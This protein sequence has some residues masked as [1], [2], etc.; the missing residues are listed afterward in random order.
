MSQSFP[1]SVLA[2]SPNEA[3]S[4]ENVLGGD[5]L[6]RSRFRKLLLLSISLELITFVIGNSTNNSQTTP[7]HFSIVPLMILSL[8]LIAASAW[9]CVELYRFKASA[10]KMAVAITGL[11]LLMSVGSY[12]FV[13][14][15]LD[16]WPAN[17][18]VIEL[19]AAEVN[20]LL[21]GALLAMMFLKPYSSLFRN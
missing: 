12:L 16:E 15:T 7:L 4:V 1:S 20:M 11:W 3:A 13:A 19:L 21:W 6:Y 5:G 18:S 2:S 14:P 9:N 17:P 8:M 10:P